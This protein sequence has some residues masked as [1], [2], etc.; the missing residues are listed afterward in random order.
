MDSKL[1]VKNEADIYE[2][3]HKQRIYQR[4][5]VKFQFVNHAYNSWGDRPKISLRLTPC[6][7]MIGPSGRVRASRIYATASSS[8][9]SER[10]ERAQT[11]ESA[12]LAL[13]PHAERPRSRES[14]SATRRIST[15]ACFP[16]LKRDSFSFFVVCISPKR[17]AREREKLIMQCVSETLLEKSDDGKGRN[18]DEP[19]V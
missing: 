2:M 8:K 5:L 7:F 6:Y 17:D 10:R 14:C 1:L 9:A 3:H 15:L 18:I 19:F 12:G 4:Q 16:V 11:R 13:L